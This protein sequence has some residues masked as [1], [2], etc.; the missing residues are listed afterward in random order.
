MASITARAWL[1]L[2]VTALAVIPPSGDGRVTSSCEAAGTTT[3]RVTAPG[4]RSARI[5]MPDSPDGSVLLALHGYGSSAARLATVSGLE[6]RAAAS[7][8]VVVLPEGSGRPPRWALT[9]RLRGGDDLGFVAAAIDEVAARSCVPIAA[10]VV[11]GFSNGAA[12]AAEVACVLGATLPIVAVELVGGAGLSEPCAVPPARVSIVHGG[13]DAVVPLAGGPV[14]GGA[15]R[16]SALSDAVSA[17]REA[18]AVV[19]VAVLPGWGHRWP[20]TATDEALALLA[21]V[22]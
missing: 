12:F 13:A 10:V 19:D 17:W 22:S 8:S 9:G 21:D 4:D 11:A 14:L 1:T 20:A 16:A 5:T 7:G 6:A 3:V 15:L 18:G 2:A